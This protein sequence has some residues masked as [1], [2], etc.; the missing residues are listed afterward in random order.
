M[1]DDRWFKISC[2]ANRKQR[3]VLGV[4]QRIQERT[5]RPIVIKRRE[6]LNASSLL[7]LSVG[8]HGRVKA[9]SDE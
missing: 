5:C 7:K 4:S 9:S 3:I 6:A 8:V 2:K 1:Q